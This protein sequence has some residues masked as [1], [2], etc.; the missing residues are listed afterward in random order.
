MVLTGIVLSGGWRR[1]AMSL[2]RLCAI[3]AMLNVFFLGFAAA[4]AVRAP[5]HLKVDSLIAPL[6]I[7][8]KTP[9]FSWQLRDTRVGA[10]QSAYRIQVASNSAAL[11]AS[12]A[13]VWDTGKIESDQ[14]VSV[15]YA[16]PALQP[17]RR[18]Y[19]RVSVWDKDGNPYPPS[20]A[21]WW[22]T[23][24][25]DQSNWKAKWIGYELPEHRSVREGGAIWITNPG[26][27]DYKEAGDT[28]HGYRLRFDLAKPVRRADLFVTG[29]NAASAWINGRPVLAAA[30]LASWM[31]LPWESYT[32]KDVTAELRRGTN[33]LAV[34]VV[35]YQKADDARGINHSLGPMNATL[36]VENTDG[37][38]QLLTSGQEGW[39]AVF[40][41]AG[42][43]Y[44]PQF[45]DTTWA[46]PIPYEPAKGAEP[47]GRPWRTGPVKMLR[48][49]FQVSAQVISA[50][51]YA[52][53]L[54]AYKFFIN[55]QAVGD[56][57]L[58]P[59]W[60]DF[61][62]RV[63]YQVYDVTQLMNTGG[64][65]IGALLAP[66]WYTTPLA[67]YGEGY[68]YGN[69]PPALLAQLR[70][71]HA[72]GSIEWI[73]TDESWK[74]DVSPIL[75][76]EIYN[77]ETYDARRFQAGWSAAGFSQGDWRPA[78]IIQPLPVKIVSQS[79]QPIRVEKI[80]PAKAISSPT[81]GVY[82]YD[83]GQNMSG[84][85]RIRISGPAGTDVQL[86][87]GEV[88]NRDGT[89]Y[90]ENLRAAKATD[91][92]I[93][94]GHGMEEY[95]PS[96][97]FHGFRYVEVS[98]VRSKPPLDAVKAVVFHTDAPFTVQLKTGSA[99]LNQLWSNILW[100][101]RSNFVGVPSDCPQRD[102]RL[103]WTGDAQVFW[104]TAS[105]NMDLAAFS[106]KYAGDLRGT[107]VGTAMYGIFAPG[108]NTA[109]PG[110]GTG[111][112]DA[113][114]IVPWT[115]WLQTG[116]AAIIEQNWDAME[117]YLAAIK[118]SN[119]DYLWKNDYGYAFGDWLSP[120]GPTAEDLI[121]TAYWAYDADLMRQMAHAVG[122]RADEQRYADLFTNIQAA[123]NRAYVRPDGF[124]GAIPPPPIFAPGLEKPLSTVPI[125]TQTGYVLALHMNLLPHTL[126][127]SAG[128]RLVDKIAANGWRLATGFLGTPYLLSA[129][130][131]TGHAD[132]AYRLLLNTAYPSWG[133]LVEHG[134]TT[135]WE[136]WNGDQINDPSMN[137]FN[138]YAY[139]AV[140]DW[141]YRYAAGVDTAAPDA[142]FHTIVL[143]PKFDEQLGSVDFS[144]ES[145]YGVIRSAWTAKSGHAVWRLLIP[146]NSAGRL[147]L[148]Q[149]EADRFQLDGK[150]LSVSAKVKSSALADEIV[151]EIPAGEYMFQ[152]EIGTKPGQQN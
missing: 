105:Y 128:K 98:G 75:T 100:G 119:P 12:S 130:T 33:L 5:N 80:L 79:Y 102:E 72:D 45:D 108:T 136:R 62:E 25:L 82:I 101:Q 26:I 88:L 85:A 21:S 77:G 120:E 24:L 57:V 41:P 30:P 90:V 29:E 110:Y 27:P 87:F 94:A 53:A 104:R 114:V 1:S 124:V 70:L 143:R 149:R 127:A 139:G 16:G 38:T 71:E 32:V 113:G 92:F 67:W 66:G 49:E 93:L 55:G 63:P 9:E 48:R 129:L 15:R 95:Q 116:D 86:R 121:A 17:E 73:A 122:R 81:P 133:Y 96:F 126:R 138:H 137:S 132:V 58:S 31:K 117:K 7:D 89:L 76:A 141:I 74:A 52:T 40:S 2:V 148:S 11:L 22:E 54:G 34:D 3:A 43:W 28:H 142:G 111:W 64:N 144:Y 56:Q 134:A 118:A 44:S 39:R 10:R 60:M 99:M 19:W 23:G 147:A 8:S 6:G 125:D 37:S 145:P 13:D 135:M 115:S 50:R 20:D 14:S 140:A 131:D 59:G 47:V 123:F 103:G 151:Y 68:N 91:H 4:Q 83:F 112:S 65:A 78:Q 69:T 97:T 150:P 109:N 106:R 35:L 18:Y 51:L 46:R 152:V 84:V 61:R 107:Q 42:A 36:Y 146:P